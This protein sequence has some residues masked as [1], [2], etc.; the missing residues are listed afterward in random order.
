MRRDFVVTHPVHD[1]T[2][3]AETIRSVPQGASQHLEIHLYH[4]SFIMASASSPTE[5]PKYPRTNEGIR[6]CQV[7]EVKAEALEEYKKVG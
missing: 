3:S 1:F 6:M 2:G 5:Y 4:H 7:I